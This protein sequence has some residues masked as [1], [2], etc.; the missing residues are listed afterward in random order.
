MR[1]PLRTVWSFLSGCLF[2]WQGWTPTPI[3][4]SSYCCWQFYNLFRSASKHCNLLVL[5][6]TPQNLRSSFSSSCPWSSPRWSLL[7]SFRSSP[8]SPPLWPKWRTAGGS[9]EVRHRSN[10]VVFLSSWGTIAACA[11]RLRI[12]G[13]ATLSKRRSLDFFYFCA[14]NPSRAQR[15]APYP[16]TRSSSSTFDS[17]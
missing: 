15:N 4:S 16:Y 8:W 9:K 3:A 6:C 17:E 1:C 7:T 5:P 13:W 14:T 10:W 11:S 2:P 12:Y